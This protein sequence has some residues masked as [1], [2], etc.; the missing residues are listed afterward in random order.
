[1]ASN[2]PGRSF[3]RCAPDKEFVKVLQG[4][5]GR[6]RLFDVFRDFVTMAACA[7][8]NSVDKRNFKDRE[9]L[10]MKTVKKYTKE[11][12]NQMADALGIVTVALEAG[13]QDFLG[14]V[15]MSLDLGDSWRGQF[16]TPYELAK[17]MAMV[18]LT[19]APSK[20]EKEGFITL[21]DCCVGAG[22]MIIAAAD[23][24]HVQG[25]N[26]QRHMHTIAGDIDPTA[27]Y[28]AYIQASLLGMPA[29][30]YHGNSLSLEIWSEWR[31]P[32]HVLGSWDSKLA[33]RTLNEVKTV[34]DVPKEMTTID[35]LPE[36][37]NKQD[38]L[39]KNTK[40]LLETSVN[41]RGEQIGF[42]F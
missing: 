37:Q 31:T 11:E 38:V 20:I 1:M 15:F 17:L 33:R 10:Y 21:N 35:F 13:P 34:I 27:V 12:A 3:D 24:L 14:S 4:I 39:K 40:V 26:Y 18:T 32:L 16:F 9:D 28:M 7:I 23:V 36:D 5:S 30:I 42:E 8:S 19:G 29:I 25:I 22:S 41:L 6:Y 2:S